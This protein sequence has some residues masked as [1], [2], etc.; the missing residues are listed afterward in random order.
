MQK[1]QTILFLLAFFFS[2]GIVRAQDTTFFTLKQ[3]VD[4]AI[5]N[6]LL[7]QQSETQMQTNRVS[8]QQSLANLLPYLNAQG[9]QALSWGRSLNTYNY[10]YIDQRINTGNYAL[11]TGLTL[12]SGLQLQNSIKQN[13]YAY[14]ASKMDW[15]Q[16]KDNITLNVIVA[17]VQVLSNQDILNISRRQADVDSQQV[18][19]LEIQNKDGAIAPSTLYDLRGQYANDLVNIINSVN[20][21]EA[22]KVNLFQILNIPYRR[23]AQLERIPLDLP[24]TEYQENPDSVYQIALNTLPLVKAADLRV[25]AYE[26]ALK[27][28]RGQYY[29]TLSFFGS[30]STNYSDAAT[31]NVPGPT[32]INTSQTDFVTVGGSDYYI[33]SKQSGI[34]Q[35][36]SFGDQFKNNRYTQVGLQLSIPILNYFKARNN[37]KFAK[38]NLHNYENVAKATR[39][40]LQQSVEL[41]YQNMAAAYGQYKS[42]R[43]QVAAY[44]LSFEAAE[45]KFNAGVITSVDY[46]IAKNNVDKANI[47]LTAARYN[48]I[49]R[50]KIMDYY[51]GKLSW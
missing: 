10:Q 48:Y 2:L 27:A 11:N 50:S 43:D 28:A 36:I 15:Q 9:S 47:N 51:Q 26:K 1:K 44:Q 4:T 8:W 49:F 23:N 30:L 16:Q 19:R 6:N 14:D 3:C 21:L 46:V 29:P 22:S 20:I 42:Y 38:I 32:T 37:V 17:Y 39:N 40:Q 7:V 35:K 5:K 18:A 12:F 41:A 13:A 24:V 33:N 31:A 34:Q 45:A 25:R